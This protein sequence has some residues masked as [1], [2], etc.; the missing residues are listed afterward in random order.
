MLQLVFSVLEWQALGPSTPVLVQ[1]TPAAQFCSW[2]ARFLL[3][4]GLPYVAAHLRWLPGKETSNKDNCTHA[5][6]SVA[7]RAA[8]GLVYNQEQQQAGL[9]QA[10]TKQ[11][12]ARSLGPAAGV[13]AG[14]AP[15]PMAYTPMTC[16]MAVSMKV[17]VGLVPWLCNL[18]SWFGAAVHPFQV[19]AHTVHAQL[20]DDPLCINQF[21]ACRTVC[22]SH[23]ACGGP[24]W[25]LPMRDTFGVVRR[26]MRP[27][28]SR[29]RWAAPWWAAWAGC[30]RV[31]LLR[32]QVSPTAPGLARRL[33]LRGV[34]S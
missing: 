18:L 22:C 10:A 14:Q 17:M 25:R 11:L 34:S 32:H 4:V 5:V 1:G 19:V 12:S 15:P 16:M 6:S 29:R 33:C 30:W 21:Q 26:W 24:N 7:G 31:V 20:S 28:S 2:V 8:S 3:C 13:T 9:N 27:M 23:G